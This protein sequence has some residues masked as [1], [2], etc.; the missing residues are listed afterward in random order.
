MTWITFDTE[1][2]AA[3]EELSSHRG[4]VEVRPGDALAYAIASQKS[5]VVMLPSQDSVVLLTI[6]KFLKAREL[7]AQPEPVEQLHNSAVRF[8]G[9]GFLGLND[10]VVVDEP[11]QPKKWWKKLFD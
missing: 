5:S 7:V 6:T 8:V 3:L 1:T 9:G 2:R 11:E 4:G 10:E